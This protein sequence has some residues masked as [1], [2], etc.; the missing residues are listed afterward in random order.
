MAVLVGSEA[1][2]ETVDAAHYNVYKMHTMRGAFL[3]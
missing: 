1:M 2:Q 3:E